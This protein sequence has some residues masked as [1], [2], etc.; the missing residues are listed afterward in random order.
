[1]QRH[2]DGMLANAPG[3]QVDPQF[4]PA[5]QAADVNVTGHSLGGHLATWFAI[6]RRGA[7]GHAFTFN[8]AGVAYANSI[9]PTRGVSNFVSDAYADFIK[10]AGTQYIGADRIFIESGIGGEWGYLPGH[11]MENLIFGIASRYLLSLID[12]QVSDADVMKIMEAAAN[13]GDRSY[14]QFAAAL[15]AT[16]GI[17]PTAGESDGDATIFGLIEAFESGSGAPGHRDA[18]QLISLVNRSAGN[19]VQLANAAGEQGA[20]VRRALANGVPFAVVVAGTSPDEQPQYA[21][22]NFS[23]EYLQDRATYLRVLW[24]RNSG[25][26]EFVSTV[27]HDLVY[28]DLGSSTE[29]VIGNVPIPNISASRQ[30]VF[31]RSDAPNNIVGGDFKD[32]LFGGGSG[33]LINGGGDNDLL[34]GGAGNDILIGGPGDDTANGGVGSDQYEYNAGDEH[35]CIVGDDGLGRGSVKDRITIHVPASGPPYDLG[36]GSLE[37]EAAG[38]GSFID[39]HGNRFNLD[40]TTLN[41]AIEDGGS[42]TIEDFQNGDFG[43]DLAAATDRTP[44]TPPGGATTFDVTPGSPPPGSPS[45]VGQYSPTTSNPLLDGWMSPSVI[46]PNTNFEIIEA[47]GVPGNRLYVVSGGMGDSYMTGDALDN[48]LVDDLKQ[49]PGG[50]AN[51]DLSVGNDLI[52]GGG[53]HDV[54]ETSGGDDWAFG[55]DG[56]DLIIDRPFD[57]NAWTNLDWISVAGNHSSDHLFGGSGNDFIA[58]NGGEAYMDGGDDADELY[59]GADSDELIGG[60]GNDILSGDTRL[61][62]NPWTVSGTPGHVTVTE[63]L[64]GKLG[65]ETVA[66][67]RDVL[68]GD[69]GNDTLIGGGGGDELHGGADD[70]TLLG[71]LVFIPTILTQRFSNHA[72]DP[73]AIQGDDQ[74]WGD[75]G[76][77]HLYG[78]GG[79]DRLDGG[80]GADYLFG[81]LGDDSLEGGSGNDQLVGDDTDSDLGSDELRGGDDND[82]LFGLAGRDFLYGDAGSD[83][84]VGGPGDDELYGGDGDDYVAGGSAGLYGGAGN[85]VLHGGAGQ[86]LL[87]GGD[88]DDVL[89]GGGSTTGN[90]L[91]F[92][93]GGNDTYVLAPGSGNVQITDSV[94]TNR[95]VFE[96]GVNRDDVKVTR[97]GGMVYIDYSPTEYAYMDS[98]TFD[99]LTGVEFAEGATLDHADVAHTF[100]PGTVTNGTLQLGTGVA[101]SEVSFSGWNEDLVLAYSGSVQN[102][103]DTST[104]TS[105]NIEFTTGVG[106]DYGL[107]AG[108]KVLVLTNWYRSNP[109]TYA[110]ELQASGQNPVNFVFDAGAATRTFAASDA[111]GDFVAGA[112]SADVLRGGAG[113]DV[114]SGDAGGDDLSGAAGSDLLLGGSGNDTYRFISGDGEDLIVDDA[115]SDDVVRFG[116]GI[117]PASLSVTETNA[118]L[119]VQVGAVANGDKLL[120]SNWSQGSAASIDRFVFADNTSLD[121]AQ[122]DAL[123]TGNHSPR[124]VGTILE[125][126]VR[127][128]QTLS[129]VVPAGTFSDPGDTLTY[130]ARLADGSPLPAWLGFDPVS[131]SFAGVPASADVATLTVELRVIDAGGLANSTSFDLRVVNPTLL[132]GTSGNNTLAAS[133][134]NDA[135]LYGLADQDSLTGA[136]GDDRL[137]GGYGIDTLNGAAGNDTYVYRRGDGQ[138]VIDQT[139][140]TAGQ[141][142]RLEFDSSVNPADVVYS[143]NTAGD[144]ILGFRNADSS[145]S[146]TDSIRVVGALLAASPERAVDE[147]FFHSMGTS[148]SA[149]QVAA[150]AMVPTANAD[151]LRGSAAADTIEGGAG[152]DVVLGEGG[153]DTL[154]GGAG[155]DTMSGGDGSDTYL[156]G[157]NEGTDTISSTLD[158][159]GGSVDVLRFAAGIAPGDI[160]VRT[161]GGS[162]TANDFELQVLGAGGVVQTTVK[163]QGARNETTGSQVLDEVRFTG[164]STVWTLADLRSMSL[165]STSGDDTISAFSGNETLSGGAG[166]DYLMGNDGAD[167]LIGGAG[168]D[169]LDGG[170]GNDTYRFGAAQGSDEINDTAGTNQLVLDAG[171][172]P[173]NVTLIRTSSTGALTQSQDA[174]G[175]DD[176][177][178]A[179]NNGGDQIRIEGFFNGASPRPIDQIVFGDNS[180]WNAATIDANTVNQGGTANTVAGTTGNDTLNVDHPNDGLT[181]SGG[182][183]TVVSSVNFTLPT[184]YENLTLTGTL[185]LTGKGNS[186]VNTIIGNA[187]DNVLETGY[188]STS[189][190]LQGGPGNDTYNAYGTGTITVVEAANEGIDTVWVVSPVYTAPANVEN[191]GYASNENY[192]WGS[193]SPA[194]TGNALDNVIDARTPTDDTLPN[195][196]LDGGQGA[197]TMYG[198]PTG[199][200]TTFVVDNPG[201]IV[202]NADADDIVQSS[203]SYVLPSGVGALVLTGSGNTSGT[204]NAGANVLDGY[205]LASLYASNHLTGGTGDDTYIVGTQDTLVEAAGEGNDTVDLRGSGWSTAVALSSFPNVENLTIAGLSGATSYSVQGTSADNRITGGTQN[206]TLS[207]FDGNDI[208]DGGTGSDTLI[209]GLGNDTYVIDVATDVITENAGEGTDTVQSAVTFTLAPALE[210]LSLTGSANIDGVGNASDNILTGNSGTNTLS[211]LGGN[212]TLYAGGAAGD[213]LIGGVG[214]DDYYL[215]VG[216]HSVVESAGEGYD[217]VFGAPPSYVLPDNVEEMTLG[218][219]DATGNALAN[220]ITGNMYR[221]SIIGGAGDDTLYGHGGNDRLDGGTGNDVLNGGDGDD[222]FVVDSLSDTV[223]EAADGGVDTLETSLTWTLATELENLLL[224]GAGNV[225]GTG[226]A[227]DNIMNGNAGANTLTGLAGNDVLDGGAGS[228]T[229]IGGPGHDQYVVDSA[230]DVVVEV[231]GEGTDTVRTSVSYAAGTGVENVILATGSLNIDATGNGLDNELTGNDG[232]N[233]LEGGGGTDVMS[234]GAGNDIYVIDALDTITEGASGGTDTIETPN[235]IN[236]NLS[237]YLNFENVTLTGSAAVNATGNSAGNVLVGNSAANQLS[238]M[239]GADTMSGGAGDD[240]YVVE[241]AGDVVTENTAEGTDLVRSSVTYTLASNV[242]NLTLFGTATISGTGNSADNVLIGNTAGNTLTGLAGNDTFDGGGGTDTMLGGPGDDTYVVDSTGDVTTENAGEGTDHV[243]ASRDW[244]LAANVENLTLTG[245]AATGTGNALN[246]ILTGNAFANT[247]DGGAG[248]DTLIGG[249]GND[250]YVVDNSGDVIVENVAEGTDLVQASATCTISAEVEN[251]TLTGTAAINATGNS[252]DNLLTGNSGVNTLTGLGGND[253]LN[254]GTGADTLIGG[255]GNDLYVVDNA[256]DV[257]TES[258]GAGTDLVQASVTYTL[259]AEV[260]NLTLTGS[261]AISGTGNALNNVLTG[262]SGANTLTGAAGNDILDGGSGND[263][264]VGGAGD[265]TF[266]VNAT[267]DVVT[268]NAGEGTDTIQSAVTY[269]ASANVENLVLTGTSAINA[270]GNTLNNVLT[271][272]TGNNTL[273]GGTGADTMTGGAGNDTYVVDDA[274]DVVTELAG[275]GVDTV[276]SGITYA[277]GSEV[278]NLTLTGTTAINGTGNGLA[279]VLTG[280]TA[281]N[282][283]TG[284]AGN[285]TLD[286]GAGN[287]TMVGGTGDDIYTVNVATDV[288]TEN[289]GE[290]TDTVNS[291]V[292]LTLAANVENLTLT[293]SSAINGTGNALNNALT[294]NSGANTLDGGTGTDSMTGGSGNDI[295]VVDNA[296][297]V[298]TELAG[299][300]TDTVQTGLTYTLGADVENLALTGTAAVNGTGN[301]LNNTLTGNTANNTLTGLGGNDTLNG[302][303][304]SDTMLG[305]SGD[306]IYVV[307]VA[308]DVVTELAGEGVD[309]VQSGITYALGSEVENLTLTGTTAI[310]GTGNGLA[311]VLTG[312]TANNTLTGGAGNDTLDGGTGNDTMVGGTGDDVYT[313]NVA[314]DVVTENVGEGTDRINSSVTLTLAANV[315]NLT[316]TGTSALSGTGNTLDNVLTGNS[317]ANTL[318]GLAGND[319][320]DGGTGNDTMVGGQGNDTYFVN[321][322]TDIITENAGEGTDTVN[323]AATLTLGNNL[324][325]L[326]LTGTSAINGTGNALDNVINGNSAVNTLSGAAGND[327]LEGKAGNDSLTGGDGAD[328]YRFS[329]GDGSD[330]I[331]NT[332]ADAAIDRLV[333]TNVTRA[334][335]SFTRTGNDLV[336][337]RA[338]VPTDKVTVTGW[339]TATGNRI[340]FVDTSD[341]LSTTADAID[342]LIGGGRSVFSARS[343]A[344]AALAPLDVVVTAVTAG[345]LSQ[346]MTAAAGTSA[347]TVRTGHVGTPITVGPRVEA[348]AAAVPMRRAPDQGLVWAGDGLDLQLERFIHAM[349][350]FRRDDGIDATT[351]MSHIADEVLIST[352]VTVP[353]VREWASMQ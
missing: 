182:T 50:Y 205:T 209:G 335:L 341:A 185:D 329:A 221:N 266:I 191:I 39:D 19:L 259:S 137:E 216:G 177:V 25:D 162:G 20:A 223:V 149:T 18:G 269:T 218:D 279:N 148:L 326:T 142:D 312:N 239:A 62:S 267:G 306:D 200:R 155:N 65:G 15:R 61:S 74:L 11:S 35:L 262:N 271:G 347:I 188:L 325:D 38:S 277:L 13:V 249:A 268:E 91:L 296:G 52:H 77:D 36:S 310:N 189:D 315:E 265:D 16:F 30:V 107:P 324:E 207:G 160:R 280:N 121:R 198:A 323:S 136:A 174:T 140:T 338:A 263:T 131:R 284:G 291:S 178:V 120:I 328:V 23:N 89:D 3:Y 124:V 203:I 344:A 97:S 68:K 316:L 165:V 172:L 130:S 75:A 211:G 44:G 334:E 278:E 28:R 193:G 348:Y 206:N 283:L 158:T 98:A 47:T 159:A 31:G 156:V 139:D 87:Q 264:L 73:V 163:V 27:P 230:G 299:G 151:Y 305:G 201:D 24:K 224:T 253:T 96:G 213:T 245:V 76:D 256:G 345:P 194:L 123:N 255:A 290:G 138:D 134:T 346:L 285:D 29:T 115:G 288:V 297:D 143:T 327:T 59:G 350:N 104:L 289:A 17:S 214:N 37:R 225:N 4:L 314:T 150:L 81:G 243:L 215:G 321:V 54:I 227:R 42:I 56:N 108:T 309:T 126:R 101:T 169:Q 270:T 208:L 40:G 217:R 210:N 55:D 167:T 181:G 257:V 5:L 293:G 333:F 292:T 298:V 248:A 232:S 95:V 300:G 202:L 94:G 114:L 352:R 238:G 233:R 231:A 53:G 176:L 128:G 85:D 141:F 236:I 90:D 197:D 116:A 261:S 70:D 276:Q 304:G 281:N 43:I 294:G 319:T 10:W 303:T 6:D 219:L 78:G 351:A 295:Y 212:D 117:A 192:G 168:N 7:L 199:F 237:T 175:K 82:T 84:L 260:E 125:Q 99:A 135:D 235:T 132:M 129:Y 241:N 330:T 252:L 147:I 109:A 286:G 337:T 112:T 251:V 195:I 229:L 34:D 179:L 272:N 113:G 106:T 9:A 21:L 342:A 88:D 302:G 308:G 1:M 14:E 343:G 69:A 340:D 287:D 46:A 353:P 254:G 318:T 274:G 250:T 100:E 83:A 51:V 228:D 320:L 63:D 72:T 22:E 144:L 86:D 153:N 187:G 80:T 45:V 58:G 161:N 301:A 66:Y 184:G 349:A 2:W 110:R 60:A 8:G 170:A 48:T 67:A 157:H 127:V 336:I 71:D 183:D 307:D 317:G 41:I 220:V 180:V 166:N 93:E 196:K 49:I 240:T 171:I 247:L 122:I 234:G 105:R 32:R 111:Q 190:T 103:V 331:N 204:G 173:A 313:V 246:N 154:S 145:I 322:A 244:T 102:W 33:D 186:S 332:S 152:N 222:T 118:G 26:K 226:N 79:A 12:P 57:G 64:N 92:G 311:N 258:A 242:E 146:A 273:S 339:F 282:T 133:G 275:E 119:E 164:D